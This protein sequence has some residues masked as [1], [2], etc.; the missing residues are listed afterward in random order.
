VTHWTTWLIPASAVVGTASGLL[1]FWLTA[2][3]FGLFPLVLLAPGLIAFACTF[4]MRSP[5]VRSIGWLACVGCLFVLGLAC[6]DL[7]QVALL[8]GT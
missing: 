4:A 3:F 8:S 2:G 5:V 1:I 6:V 7:I